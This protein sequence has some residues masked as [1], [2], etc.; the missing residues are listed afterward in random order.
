MKLKKFIQYIKE[1][2]DIDVPHTSFEHENEPISDERHLTNRPTTYIEVE[3][4]R[5]QLTNDKDKAMQFGYEYEAEQ[6]AEDHN[7]TNYSLE[8]VFVPG[9]PEPL[10]MINTPSIEGIYQMES[11]MDFNVPTKQDV[12][13][14]KDYPQE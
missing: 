1:D 12:Y 8:G 9:Q 5:I 3:D 6:F 10:Y 11:D 13:R 2:Y 14:F 4:G 7:I